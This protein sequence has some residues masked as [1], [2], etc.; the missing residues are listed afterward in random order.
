MTKPTIGKTYKVNHTR[1]GTFTGIV[2]AINGEWIDVEITKGKARNV[3]SADV[4]AGD[5]VTVR[6]TQCTFTEA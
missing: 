4:E 5:S 2:R 6:D 1:K 3:A